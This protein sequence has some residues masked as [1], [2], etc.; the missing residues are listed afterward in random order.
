[1]NAVKPAAVFLSPDI[2][3]VGIV[4]R[5]MAS[6]GH[7]ALDKIDRVLSA[8]GMKLDEKGA[9][10]AVEALKNE[11]SAD[12]R[13]EDVV[14][15]DSLNLESRGLGVFPTTLDWKEVQ[16]ICDTYQVDALFVLEF[17]DTDTQ[18]AYELTSRSLPNSIGIKV[19]VPYHRVTLNTL[20]TNGWRIYDP[21]SMQV[22]D[23]FSTRDQIQSTGEGVNP[24]KAVEAVHGREVAVMEESKFLGTQYAWRIRPVTKR[25]ARDYFVRGTENFEIAKRRAQTGDWDGAAALWEQEL[26]HPK[27]KVAGRACYN[28]AIISE[29][30]GDLD[31]AIE[32]ASRSY[33]DYRNKEALHYIHLLNYRMAEQAELQRQLSR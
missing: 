20:I 24:V 19:K 17:Y 21:Y 7:D 26:D 33:T 8:E 18:A 23:E 9:Q 12:D 4:N 30:H 15:I 29:I 28:M 27:R 3:T 10:A 1:M 11:L 16:K 32:W 14:Q 2:H 6:E 22:L 13:F 5:S 25:I 31:K